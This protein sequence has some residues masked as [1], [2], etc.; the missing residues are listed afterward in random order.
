VIATVPG[1]VEWNPVMGAWLAVKEHKSGRLVMN[2]LDLAT[3]DPLG[4]WL[5]GRILQWLEGRK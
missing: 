4:A 5:A 2:T 1:Q 3:D